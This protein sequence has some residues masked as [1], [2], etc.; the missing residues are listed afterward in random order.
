[1][2]RVLNIRVSAYT[3]NEDDVAGTWPGLCFLVWP[4]WADQRGVV[5]KGVN[6]ERPGLIEDALGARP[7]GVMELCEALRDGLKFSGW[8]KDL[9]TVLEKGIA[10]V[11]AI[12]DRLEKDL[13]DW[14]PQEALAQSN[15][16]EEALGGAEQAL[17]KYWRDKA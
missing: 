7:H 3:Y 9:A 13:A 14:N 12:K 15:A 10:D 11:S 6:I 4:Y 8:E 16:L 2:G 1:M 17:Q 5:R